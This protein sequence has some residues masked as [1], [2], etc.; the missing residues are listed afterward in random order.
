MQRNAKLMM[1]LPAKTWTPSCIA[2]KVLKEAA[3][4]YAREWLARSGCGADDITPCDNETPLNP[5]VSTSE[6]IE[7]YFKAEVLP[8]RMV[9]NL[10]A[11]CEDGDI[12]ISMKSLTVIFM[13]ISQGRWK[14]L[15]RTWDV[16][17]LDYETVAEVRIPD[18]RS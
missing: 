18:G 17:C 15:M 2:S 8:T 11:R 1:P 12:W 10:T 6:R 3:Q 4:P 9:I 7:G 5:A 16:W 13:F 14:K